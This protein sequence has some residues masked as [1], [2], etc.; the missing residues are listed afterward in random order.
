MDT[1]RST[2]DKM[3]E[4]EMRPVR[5]E[6]VTIG[7]VF[8]MVF[9][10]IWAVLI[11]SVLFA[12]VLTIFIGF[13]VNPINR[14][15]SMEFYFSYPASGTFKYPDGSD[16][17]Y[18]E[19]ISYES[20]NSAKASDERFGSIDIDTMLREDD[21]SVTP[22]YEETEEG[23]RRTGNYIIA[24]D[25]EYFSSRETAQA[26]IRA[27]TQVA[28]DGV[29]EK[30]QSIGYSIDE[31]VF[32]DATFEDRL[33]LLRE[34]RESILGAYDG[35]I[36]EY[37]AGYAVGGKTLSAYR[38][39]AAVACGDSILNSLQEELELRGYVTLEER[40]VTIAKLQRERVINEDK[41]AAL[42]EL[43]ESLPTTEPDN[44]VQKMIADL[45]VRNIQIDSE[46]A[47]LTDENIASFDARVNEQYQQLQKAAENVN[48]VAVALY[49]QESTVYFSSYRAAVTGDI[50]LIIVAVGG[51]IV[52]FFIAAVVVCS[53]ET[54]RARKREHLEA[55]GTPEAQT[56]SAAGNEGHAASEE[57]AEG[58]AAG[59]E[60]PEEHEENE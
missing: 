54:K 5:E 7:E 43:L 48:A 44:D 49:E 1:D 17:S 50:S 10:H 26:F 14:E 58:Q 22:V 15:Y 27:I 53:V 45:E 19:F 56:S 35:W 11:A 52:A 36:S 30:T 51:F 41:I 55:A 18:Y 60:Q 24:V 16:F 29:L 13:V 21:I 8:R 3:Q 39:E 2:K 9:K 23:E 6:G 25:G 32:Q 34:G 57:A 38:A 31:E 47:S 59:E 12:A 20:L 46:I 37:R 4:Q 28:L 42:R 33:T 40:D